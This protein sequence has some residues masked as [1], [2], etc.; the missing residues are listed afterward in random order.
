MARV[1]EGDR[2]TFASRCTAVSEALIHG[3]SEAPGKVR[4]LCWLDK[5]M[6]QGVGVLRNRPS[7]LGPLIPQSAGLGST[8]VPR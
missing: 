5:A 3:S 4:L 2:G 7:Q 8:A 6:G 1:S